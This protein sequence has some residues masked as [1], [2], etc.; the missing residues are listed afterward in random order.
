MTGPVPFSLVVWFVPCMLGL[1]RPLMYPQTNSLTLPGGPCSE[2]KIWGTLAPGDTELL[3]FQASGTRE[4][5]SC[6]RKHHT[7]TSQNQACLTIYSCQRFEMTVSAHTAHF[8]SHCYT[9]WLLAGIFFSDLGNSEEKNIVSPLSWWWNGFL[10]LSSCWWQTWIHSR[11]L[12]W[13]LVMYR[14]YYNS[15]L[16]PIPEWGA[17]Q[18]S[19]IVNYP[20]PISVTK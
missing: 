6:H 11:N 10:L 5:L 7:K 14:F 2:V 15:K 18:R 20:R 4:K 12:Y 9:P 13:A 19:A 1:F 17:G 3:V 8:K 16:I